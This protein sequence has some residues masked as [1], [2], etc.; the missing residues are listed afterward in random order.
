MIQMLIQIID[1]YDPDVIVTSGG[2]RELKFIARRATQL[3]LGGLS[4]NRDKR[5]FPFYRT[6]KSSKERGNSFMSYGGHFYKETSFHLYAGRH[7]FDM[8]NSFTWSDGGFA[9]IVELARLSC[10]TPQSCCRGSIGTLLTG[11]QILE[12]LQ[13]DILIPGKKAGV[14]NFRTGTSLLNADRG[15]FIVSPRVGLHFNVLEVDFLSMFPTI[16]VNFNVSPEA[17]NCYCCA[18]GSGLPVPNTEYY[19]CTKKKGLIPKVLEQILKR[20]IYYKQRKK[21]DPKYDQLQKA[22]KWILVT[23]FGYLGYRNARWGRIDAHETINAYA[24]E[25]I[26]NIVDLAEEN[27]LECIAG[28]VDSLWMK[29]QAESPIDDFLPAFMTMKGAEI[30]ALPISVEGVYKWIVFLPRLNEPEV[31][32][33]NRYYGVY[34]DGSMK[35][36]GIEI[37]KRDTPLFIKEAQQDALDNLA[38]ADDRSDFK[39]KIKY[40]LPRLYDKWKQKLIDQEV[41][42]DQLI[43]TKTLSKNPQDYRANNHSALVSKQLVKTGVHLQSGMKVQYLV[44][45]HTN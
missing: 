38:E 19:T 21:E 23:S 31:G 13:T 18:D 11:M 25:K 44:T 17:M 7:H 45:D 40:S 22:L 5:V 41:P 2:D 20:R 3:G 4:F 33:L 24:R 30:T 35:I 16:M 8:R 12:A 9:G 10:M 27:N 29:F 1:E 28:I 14:E 32:V 36:R 42:L 43:V 15:G 39:F 6:A 26:L 34:Q 37:R